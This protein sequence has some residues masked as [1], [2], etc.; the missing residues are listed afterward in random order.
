ME[1]VRNGHMVD[2]TGPR[3]G[4]ALGAALERCW[5]AGRGLIPTMEVFEFLNG[6]L[7][8]NP[9]TRYFDG[10]EHWTAVDHWVADHARGR[11]LDIGTGAG[12]FAK[13]L[14]ERAEVQDVVGIDSSPG[15]VRVARDRG[16]GEVVNGD[17]LDVGHDL[18][19]FDTILLLG[20]NLGLLGHGESPD[21]VLARLTAMCAEGGSIIGTAGRPDLLPRE[22]REHNLRTAGHEGLCTFRLRYGDLATEWMRYYFLN[23]ADL[24]EWSRQAGWH[25]AEKTSTEMHWAAVLRSGT[26]SG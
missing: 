11:V 21:A 26:G 13:E 16:L 7:V 9:L 25:V 12:R 22:L 10:P 15:A 24:C 19:K 14:A 18:G 8:C 17:F 23:V 1:L 5:N 4:D 3:P 6:W 2:Y 20:N